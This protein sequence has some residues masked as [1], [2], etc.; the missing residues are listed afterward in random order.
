MTGDNSHFNVETGRGYGAPRLGRLRNE[1]G[2]FRLLEN[3]KVHLGGGG[4]GAG[5]MS[6]ADLRTML[7]LA[8]AKLV[9]KLPPKLVAQTSGTS[10]RR[11]KGRAVSSVRLPQPDECVVISD[12]APS[13]ALRDM[14]KAAGL[15]PVGQK[16]LCDSISEFKPLER[17]GYEEAWKNK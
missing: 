16:W 11:G 12:E 9:D 10:A 13:K 2:E 15:K 14:C 7:E 6:T 1:G 4:G 5:N 3:W 17:A 8:G